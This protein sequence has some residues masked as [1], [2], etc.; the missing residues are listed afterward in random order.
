MPGADEYPISDLSGVDPPHIP[1][2]DL[3][4]FAVFDAIFSS[5]IGSHVLKKW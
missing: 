5:E 3:S 2:R 1:E 4:G